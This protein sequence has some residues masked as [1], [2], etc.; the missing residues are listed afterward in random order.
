MGSLVWNG[1]LG[2]TVLG[3]RLGLWK[4]HPCDLSVGYFE[5]L[6]AWQPQGDQTVYLAAKGLKRENPTEQGRALNNNKADLH[7]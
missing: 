4:A 2:D 6:T 5:L 3:C 1:P 7:S